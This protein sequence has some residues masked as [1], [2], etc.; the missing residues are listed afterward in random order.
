MSNGRFEFATATRIVFGTPLAE[1]GP[2]LAGLDG[3]FLL[4]TGRDPSRAAGL[5]AQLEA[6]GGEVHVTTVDGEPTLETARAATA[7]AREK[8]CRTVIGL[9]G[10]SVVDLAKAIGVL[11]ANG[12]D[13]LDYVEVIGRGQPLRHPSVPVVAIPTTAG[14][15]S[16]VTR[17][18]VLA[19]P[20]HRVKVSLRSPHML[21]RLAFVDPALGV[22]MSP[23]LTAGTG[24]DALSQTM[25]AFVC[26]APNALADPLCRES[27][28]RAAQAL[29]RAYADGGDLTA[30][31]DMCYVSLVGGL[32]L[33]N[34]RL[35]AVH[36]FAAPLGGMFDA[37][38]GALCAAL[39]APVM[40]VNIAV[41]RERAPAHPS[42]DRY[43]EVARLLTGR[44]GAR[45]EEGADWVAALC[46]T[47]RVAPLRTYGVGEPDLPAVSE[48]AAAASSM[49]GNPIP[50]TAAE[51]ER[52]LRAAL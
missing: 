12:G 47:M 40:R 15:G 37:P 41:L 18:A 34:A 13:P 2:E 26:Q 1:I 35:G 42:L 23:T 16:E 27:L 31:R 11:L 43:Q 49:K 52:I 51:R 24:M 17:N 45:A 50:L 6:T 25:E 7:Q 29:P 48:K 28:A 36:G 14:T 46:E 9:G 38:H 32:A 8:G 3:P 21:P 20:E 39:L 30:R 19:S 4:V 10:G 33:A 22:S 44:A 5:R